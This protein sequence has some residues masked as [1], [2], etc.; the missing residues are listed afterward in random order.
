MKRHLIAASAIALASPAYA[1]PYTNEEMSQIVAMWLTGAILLLLY[2]IPTIIA[3]GR[4][5]HSRWAIM[6][7]NL[8]LGWSG[9]GWIAALIWSLTGVR[10]DDVAT[11]S[12]RAS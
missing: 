3:F 12:G 6:M 9:L 7:T 2:L 11:L 8:L 1:A 4:R 5:H 10:R